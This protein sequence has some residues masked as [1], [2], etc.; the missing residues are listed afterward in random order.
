MSIGNQAFSPR[1]LLVAT[2]DTVIWFWNGPDTNHS[3][4]ADAGQGE[5]FDSDPDTPATLVRHDKNDAYSH[6]FNKIGTYRYHCKVHPKAMTGTIEVQKPPKV[7]STPPRVSD[8]S[9]TPRPVTRTAHVHFHVSEGS[10]VVARVRRPGSKRELRSRAGF[11]K[12][13]DREIRVPVKRLRSGRYRVTLVA[14]DDA[15]NSSRPR[16]V[17]FRIA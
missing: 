8:L 9:V 13:G 14:E 10:F 16:S 15:A 11:F 17:R 12:R 7:D 2:G 3:V 6:A 4:T 1:T 5:A